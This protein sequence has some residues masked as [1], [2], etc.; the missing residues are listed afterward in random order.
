MARRNEQEKCNISYVNPDEET[1]NYDWY[2]KINLSMWI[3]ADFEWKNIPVDDPQLKTLF[4]NKR[5][6]VCYNIK[7]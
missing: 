5:K 4:V 3:A 1:K 6:A 2:V 7:L